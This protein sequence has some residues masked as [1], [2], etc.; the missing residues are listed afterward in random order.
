MLGKYI[1][2]DQVIN[3]TLQILIG[4][5]ISTSINDKKLR[6]KYQRGRISNKKIDDKNNIMTKIIL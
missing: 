6:R 1:K 3:V 4:V 5:L 2:N